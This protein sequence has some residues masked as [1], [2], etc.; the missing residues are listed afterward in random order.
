MPIFKRKTLRFFMKKITTF[1]ILL[2]L[3]TI[4]T[5]AQYE[6]IKVIAR[7]KAQGKEI[8]IERGKETSRVNIKLS[9]KKLLETIKDLK[10]GDEA[11]MTGHFE[12]RMKGVEEES[13]SPIFVIDS[14]KPI[15]LKRLGEMNQKI[16]EKTLE[17]EKVVVFKSEPPFEPKSLPVTGSVAS[18]ITMTLGLLML[19]DLSVPENEPKARKDLNAG[20]ILSAGALATGVFIYEQIRGKEKVK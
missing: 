1:L 20:L 4:K 13:S 16:N 9:H 15:S 10:P 17:E 18:A 5:S 7:I 2:S 8:K 3:F 6:E 11:L 14:I 19:Q 12:Y